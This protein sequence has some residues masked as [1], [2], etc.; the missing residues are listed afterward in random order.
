MASSFRALSHEYQSSF[1]SCLNYNSSSEAEQAKN[2]RIEVCAN[3]GARNKEERSR[4]GAHA[5][6]APRQP[7]RRGER[8]PRAIKASAY[9]NDPRPP[10]L[11]E[12]RDL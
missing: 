9:V 5:R 2:E 6:A 4:P 7:R 12:E 8:C 10:P 1:H 3:N 11:P